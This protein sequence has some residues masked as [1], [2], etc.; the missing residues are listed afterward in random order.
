MDL[1]ECSMDEMGIDLPS[2]QGDRVPLL[3]PPRVAADLDAAGLDPG[4]ELGQV[5]RHGALGQ[6]RRDKDP[7]DA[8]TRWVDQSI[9]DK[10][11]QAF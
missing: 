4:S 11:P 3:V 10:G 1:D 5:G 2:D 9:D 6:R 7:A 8:G